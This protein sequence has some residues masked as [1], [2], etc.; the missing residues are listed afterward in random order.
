VMDPGAAN[1][2]KQAG[3]QL[4]RLR[5][6]DLKV[7]RGRLPAVLDEFVLNGLSFVQSTKSG[8]FDRRDVYEHI[9]PAF[10]G[11]DE[12]IA[13]RRI[14]PLYGA[15]RHARSP[16]YYQRHS[17]PQSFSCEQ[18]PQPSGRR[19]FRDI[20]AASGCLNSGSR[21]RDLN[22]RP[23]VYKTLDVRLRHTTNPF[24]RMLRSCRIHA[25]RIAAS[26][27]AIVHPIL[28]D[29]LEKVSAKV[30]GHPN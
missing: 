7:L 8:A 5:S 16:K 4:G 10:L 24:A 1:L 2:A 3:S 14:E 17:L 26:I 20:L 22:L 6:L 19:E 18:G 23:T 30:K 21:M 12:A 25:P 28:F 13:L 29:V 11:L 27:V 15:L 9:L